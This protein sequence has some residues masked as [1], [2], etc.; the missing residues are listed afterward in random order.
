MCIL[1][2]STVHCKWGED[3]GFSLFL[4]PGCPLATAGIET[5]TQGFLKAQEN[6]LSFWWPRCAVLSK[7]SILTPILFGFWRPSS[8][9]LPGGQQIICRRSSLFPLCLTQRCSRRGNTGG[10]CP[11]CKRVAPRT[12]DLSSCQR[13]NAA[14]TGVPGKERRTLLMFLSKC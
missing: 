13:S 4:T 14:A 7:L 5:K 8:H 11:G 3:S 12:L 10:L 6:A 9:A 1:Q 2:I